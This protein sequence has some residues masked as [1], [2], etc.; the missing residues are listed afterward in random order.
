[1]HQAR[2]ATEDLE[3]GGRR[4]AEND[5]VVMWYPSAN[6]DPE[7][8]E[9]PD[10]FDVT[11]PRPKHLSFG[12]GRHFCLGNQLAR[13]ELRISLEETLRRLPGL[14]LDGPVVKKPND[15]FHWM[16]GMPVTFT[17]GPREDR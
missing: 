8:L 13:L 5:K 15:S 4:I 3:L 2:T 11:R 1:M 12:A 9:D 16:V 6:R 7:L 17:P 10:R 14:E